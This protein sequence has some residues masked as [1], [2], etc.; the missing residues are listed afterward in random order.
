MKITSESIGN[1]FYQWA[2]NDLL[3]KSSIFQQGIITFLLLQGK[4][5]INAI[6]SGLDMLADDKKQFDSDELFQNLQKGLEKMGGV[7]R[8]PI[9]DYNFDVEDLRKV[10]SYLRGVN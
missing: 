4:P 1:A 2:E 3:A 9:I 7:Y 6:F 10:K 8:L 5:R